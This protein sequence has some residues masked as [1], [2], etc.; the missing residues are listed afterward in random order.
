MI[1]KLAII[2]VFVLV[3]CTVAGCTT[4]TTNTNQTPNTTSSAATQ[5]DAFLENYL[6]TYKNVSYS[7]STLQIKAWDLQ[8]INSTSARLEWTFLNKTNKTVN[9]EE[10]FFV[11]ATS[12]DATDY[13][14]AMNTTAYSLVSTQYESST[15]AYLNVTGHA[16]Q[17]YKKYVW[18]EGNQ[19]NI[20]EYRVHQIGQLDN[21]VVVATVK[22]LG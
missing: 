14:N 15:G 21:I 8:W 22:V 4:T 2:I 19:S 17:I 5:H 7:N 1:K 12:Q 16:P 6:T 11:F 10:T 18:N 20:S 9:R 13:V 3:V